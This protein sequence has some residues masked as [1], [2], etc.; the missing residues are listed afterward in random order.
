MPKENTSGSFTVD[1]PVTIPT[2]D[3]YNAK[4]LQ[5]ISTH[6]GHFSHVK[7][8]LTNNAIAGDAGVVVASTVSGGNNNNSSN[9]I[10]PMSNWYAKTFTGQTQYLKAGD[11]TLHLTIKDCEFWPNKYRLLLDD[12]RF[13]PTDPVNVSSIGE[14]RFEFE[15]FDTAL[16]AKNAC[17]AD[18]TFVDISAYASGGK[19]VTEQWSELN[20]VPYKIRIPITV[21]ETNAYNWTSVMTISGG[22]MSI[23]Y[24]GVTVATTASTGEDVSQN[25]AFASSNYPMKKYQGNITMTKGEHMLE[26]IITGHNNPTFFAD[27]FA[28]EVG[29]LEVD[30]ETTIEMEDYVSQFT[31]TNGDW[32]GGKKAV[33]GASGDEVLGTTWGNTPLSLVTY[34]IPIDVKTAGY[35]DT[36]YVVLNFIDN[37]WN[38]SVLWFMMDNQFIGDNIQEAGSGGRQNYYKPMTSC[39]TGYFPLYKMK[40]ATVYLTEGN[41]TIQMKVRPSGST[42]LSGTVKFGADYIKLTPAKNITIPTNEKKVFELEDYYYQLAAKSANASGGELLYATWQ[43]APESVYDILTVPITITEKGFYEFK[44]PFTLAASAVSKLDLTLDGEKLLSN[45]NIDSSAILDPNPAPASTPLYMTNTTKL[46][47]PGTYELKLTLTCG[48]TGDLA[49]TVL[50]NLQK[51]GADYISIERIDPGN[52]LEQD[53]NSVL[54]NK[55]IGEKVTGKAYA[56]FYLGGK[57][58]DVKTK[59]V[60]DESSVM[61]NIENKTWKDYDRASVYVWEE[62]KPNPLSKEFSYSFMPVNKA[63]FAD[64]EEEI[65]VVFIGDSLYEAYSVTESHKFSTQVGEWFKEQYEDEDTKVNYYNKGAGG[66]TSEYSLARVIRDVVD[67]EPDVVFFGTTINDGSRDTTRNMESVIRTLQALENPPYIIMTRFPTSTF[68]G[69]PSYG[70]TLADHYGIPFI[71]TTKYFE[72]AVA[73][74]AV[75]KDLFMDG[76]H[77]NDDGNDIQSAALIDRIET[78][79]YFV[80]GSNTTPKLLSTSGE[81]DPA[82]ADYFSVLDERVERSSGWTVNSN[83]VQTTTAGETLKFKFT[84]NIL[85]F[86]Y[87]LHN[88][89]AQMQVYVDGELAF[90]CDP[91]YPGH[92]GFQKVCKETSAY[93]DLPDGEH[94]VEMKVIKSANSSVTASTQYM[95]IY[96]FFTASWAD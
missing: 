10:N 69:V 85:A 48:H 24:D 63:P 34:S 71:D 5:G 50:G 30:G 32:G 27:Y 21:Q 47:E 37:N 56:A 42:N 36:E 26:L 4:Y 83:N 25:G 94:E 1:I 54:I 38:A 91:Y 62:G 51:F 45:S 78:N 52:L 68:G 49:T 19:I 28:L 70:K 9:A 76:V 77:P 6:K 39:Y 89:A 64:N 16:A 60:A 55:S 2:S 88:D 79:R 14:T 67:L 61:F 23:T 13:V 75:M 57:L 7:M 86:N 58:V 22:V 15:D 17:I 12:I 43:H 20:G 92:T 65:N 81:I 93:F 41:H 73:D 95:R 82:S 59:D 72:D 35:Y 53:E 44:A 96:D 90:T 87:G 46:L 31:A 66:T 11:Y 74:G 80:K 84:G 33:Q 8:T 40:G 18:N 3:W 29:R